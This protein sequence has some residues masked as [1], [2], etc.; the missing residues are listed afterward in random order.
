[1]MKR[2]SDPVPVMD[3]SDLTTWHD[4]VDSGV[5]TVDCISCQ[6]H[7]GEVFGFLGSNS[8]RK[9]TTIWMRLGCLR[10]AELWA[11]GGHCPDTAMTGAGLAAR[12]GLSRCLMKGEMVS[13]G[14]REEGVKGELTVGAR[15]WNG[16]FAK[17]QAP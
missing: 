8:A 9:T 4:P 3:V 7:Q 17:G 5:L 2:T 16:G 6:V 10:K 11:T 14:Q 15:H 12:R 13:L 1:M